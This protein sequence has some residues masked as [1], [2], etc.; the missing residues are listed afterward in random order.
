MSMYNMY[1]NHLWF[2]LV[3]KMLGCNSQFPMM[4]KQ[5][6]KAC[7]TKL[8]YRHSLLI[9]FHNVSINQLIIVL[10]KRDNQS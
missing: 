7:L 1:D 9:T 8:E 3:F 2:D 4:R 10:Y 5:Y 6:L